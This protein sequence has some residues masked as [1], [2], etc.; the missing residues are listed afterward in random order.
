MYKT[1]RNNVF[2]MVG[3]NVPVMFTETPQKNV[4]IALKKLDVFNVYKTFRNN[5]FIT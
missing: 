3:W 4:L 1:F 2:K 5:V